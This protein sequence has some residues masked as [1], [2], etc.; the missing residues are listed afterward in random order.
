MAQR[1]SS[2]RGG[3]ATTTRRRAGG[4][5]TA[6]SDVAQLR[7]DEIRKRLRAYGV[8][9]ISRLRKPELVQALVKAERSGGAGKRSTGPSGRAATGGRRSAP[10]R[11]ASTRAKQGG[12]ERTT[13]AAATPTRA[14]TRTGRASSRS[15]RSSQLIESTADRPERPGRSLVTANHEVIQRWARARGAKPA[16]IAGTE[17]DGRAGVLTFDFPGYRESRRLR[18]ITWNEWF[19]T[20][21]ERRL[22]LIYQEQLRDGRPSNFFRTESPDREDA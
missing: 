1:N 4:R 10:A 2:G 7:V 14:A 3:A 16:T 17:R 9:G 6:A 13:R 21:D 5:Q 11:A 15:V 22:N 20:F 19:R 18:Q 8:S 12:P